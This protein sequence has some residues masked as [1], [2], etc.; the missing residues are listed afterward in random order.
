MRCPAWRSQN[1]REPLLK[2]VRVK[3]KQ[4]KVVKNPKQPVP[5]R[6]DGII[7]G[8]DS[9][10]QTQRSPEGPRHLHRIPRLSE[11]KP[12]SQHAGEKRGVA[13]LLL[14]RTERAAMPTPF[15]VDHNKLWKIL[16]EMGI[17]DHLICLLRNLYAGQ[18][19]TVRTGHG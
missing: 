3:K 17:P 16:K 2:T 9:M 8:N 1:G 4:R 7:N 19:A 12:G 10:R 15:T 18:E 6:S 11:G 13:G 14:G 5:L